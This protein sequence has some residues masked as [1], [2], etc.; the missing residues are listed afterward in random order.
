MIVPSGLDL[1]AL[2]GTYRDSARADLEAA[3]V[4]VTAALSGLTAAAERYATTVAV[5]QEQLAA[6]GLEWD[7]G[8]PADPAELIAT[9][10]AMIERT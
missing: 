10:V 3:S 5:L 2:A 1:V 4:A 9:A 8:P 6:A 7:P